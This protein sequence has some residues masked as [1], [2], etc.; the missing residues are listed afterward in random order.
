MGGPNVY[1]PSFEPDE[2]PGGFVRRRSYVGRDAGAERLGATLLEL[3]PRKDRYALPLAPR[4]RGDAGR[5]RGAALAAHAGGLARARAGRG[6]GVPARR[7][8]R[9]PG[10]N[11]SEEPARYL[12]VSAM[13]GPELTVYPDSGKIGVREDAPGPRASGR[14]ELHRSADAVDY[15]EGERP[16]E[17]GA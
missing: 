12:F 14:R 6:R 9:P 5:D 4:Q 13:I 11:F 7:A 16:P 2:E 1:E 3:P 8:R 17:A 10:S 15:W